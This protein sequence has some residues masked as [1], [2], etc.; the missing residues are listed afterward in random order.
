M[1][2]FALVL[3]AGLTIGLA[4]VVASDI[5]QRK[6]DH[7]Q[8]QTLRDCVSTLQQHA[9][10]T[11]EFDQSTQTNLERMFLVLTNA[12]SRIDILA[13]NLRR[14]HDHCEM[15]ATN[16]ADLMDDKAARL[17]H[18][19][20]ALELRQRMTNRSTFEVIGDVLVQASSNYYRLHPA[21]QR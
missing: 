2:T 8:I 21:A 17:L 6:I 18:E 14:Q 10:D 7:Q 19:A 20:N 1:K 13:A 11:Q 12:C 5:A 4:A 3:L 15:V 9:T 16:V